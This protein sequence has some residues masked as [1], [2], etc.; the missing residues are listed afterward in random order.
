MHS[1]KYA[2]LLIVALIL[3]SC[4]LFS[5]KPVYTREGLNKRTVDESKLQREARVDNSN[6]NYTRIK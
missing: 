6:S 3:S 2:G 1:I 5:S 4:A